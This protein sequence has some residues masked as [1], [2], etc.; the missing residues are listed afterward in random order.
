MPV[1]LEETVT[2]SEAARIA[3]VSAETIRLWLRDG[4]LPGQITPLG[5]LIRRV[6]V[7][8]LVTQ[9]EAARRDR[10]RTRQVRGAVSS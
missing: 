1:L 9:R 8:R 2:T 5:A 6:D 3:G 7:D 4:R 10:V